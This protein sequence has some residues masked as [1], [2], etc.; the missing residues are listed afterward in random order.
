M[1]P[2]SVR[3]FLAE[4][5]VADPPRRNRR[6]WVLVTAIS[7]G[8][9]LE[10][11]L[12]TDDGW[13]D[14]PVGWRLAS[15]VMFFVAVP[16]AILVRRT[17]PLL[18]TLWGFTP[19]IAFGVV[20]ALWV[21]AFGGLN[22]VAVILIVPY[23]LFR[24]GSGRDAALGALVMIGAGI[25]GNLS[26]PGGI[27]DWI[28]GFIVLG[29]PVEAGLLVRYRNNVR[30]RMI[31]DAKSREREQLARE[32]HDTVAHHVSAIAVQAQAGQ[33]MAAN[34]PQRAV[35][36]LAVIE[37]AA[38]TTLN[39]MRTM[40]GSLRS[41]TDGDLA[42]QQGVVDL[43]R[44]AA[45]AAGALRIDVEIADELGHLTPTVD[46]AVYR[47][48]QESITNA[49]RHARR[50]QRVDVRVE[51]VGD[52]VRV[53]VTDDGEG[54]DQ[55]GGQG[56]GLLGMAERTHLLGGQFVAGP[57]TPRGWRVRADLPRLEVAS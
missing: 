48:A 12:R 4:P 39:E 54:S 53:T 33:A 30:A 16:P 15:L 50:A 45:G 57:V 52:L 23:A 5:A 55:P 20:A 26:D 2:A 34:D 49:V 46:S 56:Y 11:F 35:E 40:V 14:F 51:P 28:G 37:Q 43:P 18:A 13:T 19:T 6:D 8:A 24:W 42:P 38:T 17:R 32:L 31:E 21:G 9:V 41:G 10:A 1:I 3:S 7:V 29:I 44:L 47:I 27:G 36:I 22:L 25:F